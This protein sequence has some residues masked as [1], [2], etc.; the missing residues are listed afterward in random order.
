MVEADR[1]LT[2]FSTNQEQVRWPVLY[3]PSV[4][5]VIIGT[6]GLLW[7]LPVPEAFQAISPALNWGTTFLMAAVVYYFVISTPLAIGMLPF[8]LGIISVEAWIA[9]LTFPPPWVALDLTAVG[10][11]GLWFSRGEVTITSF[12][13]RHLQLIMIGPLWLL[14]DIYRRLRIPY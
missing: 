5:L 7:S 13:G 8:V 10:I 3:W 4:F 11:A 2:E 12:L 6:V 14:A 9:G 1:W